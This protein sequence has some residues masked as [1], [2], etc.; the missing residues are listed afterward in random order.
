[1]VMPLLNIR[2][3]LQRIRTLVSQSPHLQYKV[4]SPRRSPLLCSYFSYGPGRAVHA[5]WA[6]L[7]LQL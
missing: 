3:F 6:V 7:A 5:L 4:P 2:D 1:M